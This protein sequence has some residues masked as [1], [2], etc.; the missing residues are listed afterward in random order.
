MRRRPR[1][2][3]DVSAWLLFRAS[4]GRQGMMDRIPLSCGHGEVECQR[5]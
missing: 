1:V 3:H 4:F 2:N 5:H